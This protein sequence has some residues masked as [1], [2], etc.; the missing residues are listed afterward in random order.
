MVSACF[1]NTSLVFNL[2]K[3][4]TMEFSGPLTITKGGVYKGNF[5]SPDSLIPGIKIQTSEL[6]IIEDSV[7]ESA[8]HCIMSHNTG[9]NVIIR[10]T[11]GTCTTPTLDRIPFGRFVQL[12]G[13]TN[14]IAEN[15]EY[16]NTSSFYLY[17]YKGNYTPSNSIK[18]RFNKAININGKDRLGNRAT[19]TNGEANYVQFVQL[20]KCLKVP[21]IDISWNYIKNEYGKSLIE[22]NVNFFMSGGTAESPALVHNN[23]IDGAYPLTSTITNYSG[24]GIMIDG[25]YDP[26]TL[27]A[28]SHIKVFNNTVV[29]TVNYGIAIAGG[30]NN[31]VFNNRIVSVN[32]GPNGEKLIGTGNRGLY[33][34][35]IKK[36]PSTVFYNNRAQGNTIGYVFQDA[37]PRR[38]NFWSSSFVNTSG[39]KQ[40]DLSNITQDTYSTVNHY[41]P[42]PIT[43]ETEDNEVSLWEASAIANNIK[44]GVLPSYSLEDIINAEK[45]ALERGK[46][47]ARI[48]E[49]L[50][51][52][53]EVSEKISTFFEGLLS[54]IP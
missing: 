21:G 54:E 24:G 29:R 14:I 49:R 42:D 41:L 39:L 13:F 38:Q 26:I 18:I 46:E 30:N 3:I 33:V 52:K 15:N 47:I 9:A 25:Y 40:Y 43:R 6:V 5:R 1:S 4:N 22:D 36:A 28:S 45:A 44:L 50:A 53:R 7:I 34:W 31:E 37:T 19:R 16:E 32:L 51:A 35:N 48:E 2:Q 11:K 20:N 8:G 12:S 27:A 17:D 23:L 10:N